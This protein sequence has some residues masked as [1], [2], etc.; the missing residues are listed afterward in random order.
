MGVQAIN[1]S[2]YFSRGKRL[3]AKEHLGISQYREEI[4]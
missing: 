3:R 2:T 1:T 4:F